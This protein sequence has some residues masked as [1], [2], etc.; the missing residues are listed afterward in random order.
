MKLIKKQKTVPESFNNFFHQIV[1]KIAAKELVMFVG[2][3]I[4]M[5]SGIPPVKQLVSYILEKL[6]VMK[7]EVETIINSE[8]PF[9]AFF[10]IITRASD[11]NILLKIFEFGEPNSTHLL[12]AK[13]A[14]LRYVKTICTTNFD[15]LIETAL[16]YEGMKR[17]LHYRLFANEKE[18]ETINWD[19]NIIKIIKLHGTIEDKDNIGITIQQIAKKYLSEKR[20][21]IVDNIFQLGAHSGVLILGYSCSD[22]FDISPQIESIRKDQKSIFFIEHHPVLENNHK[23]TGTIEEVCSKEYKN[24]FRQFDKGLRVYCDTDE[25]IQ[26]IQKFF[27]CATHSSLKKTNV[28]ECWKKSVDTWANVL[29]EKKNG[30]ELSIIGEIFAKISKFEEAINYFTKANN[31]A[32]LV[33]DVDQQI[34]QLGNIGL[35]SIWLG[36]YEDSITYNEKALNLSITNKCYKYI[37]TH[38]G[39]LGTAYYYL[40]KYKKAIKYYKDA[41]KAS[42]KLGKVNGES[43]Q[44]GNIGLVYYATGEYE[45]AIEYHSD[46]LAISIE[47]GDKENEGNNCG[48]LGLTYTEIG[49]LSKAIEFYEKALAIYKNVGDIH[50]IGCQIGNL[51]MVYARQDDYKNAIKYNLEAL[52][53]ARSIS[54]MIG[55]ATHLGNLGNSY[56]TIGNY[57]KAHEFYEDALIMSESIGDR[58]G[59]GRHLNN[60]GWANLQSE[61]P[62]KAITYFDKSLTVFK[63]MLGENHPHTISALE[64][65]R[66]SHNILKKDT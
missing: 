20:K 58:N 33:R 17:G 56:F 14:K 36:K 24:P 19:E 27:N 37:D 59:Q 64:G 22:V 28:L 9:E 38:N 66:I 23:A 15:N 3:G 49:K 35:A 51:G 11:N 31:M 60:L 48:N 2:A 16:E 4:S 65:L 44:L 53:I 55:V 32:I 18:F 61:K 25:L 6:S 5:H 1:T 57:K 43:A 45:K 47:I 63:S 39:N 54:D 62:E 50:G 40:G 34:N 7:T 41:L 10:D 42:R 21:I 52:N 46:A 29:S 30:T 12:L 8:L 26:K 13:L